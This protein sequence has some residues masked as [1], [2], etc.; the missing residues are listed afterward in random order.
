MT[1]ALSA[2][3]A[4][5]RSRTRAAR[6]RLRSAARSA[7]TSSCSRSTKC[8]SSGSRRP[9]AGTATRSRS[10]AVFSEGADGSTH[11]PADRTGSSS[12]PTWA[13]RTRSCPKDVK[14]PVVQPRGAAGKARQVR[15]PDHPR[16]REV[17]WRQ[18]VRRPARAQ[19]AQLAGLGDQGRRLRDLGE[20]AA[21]R[22]ETAGS[23]TRAEAR[24]RQVA[25]GGGTAHH[26]RHRH[27]YSGDDG[28]P[29][30]SAQ[31][32]R[33]RRASGPAARAAQGPAGRR[34]LAPPGRRSRGAGRPAAS[35]SSSARTWTRTASRGGCSCA[36]RAGRS[37]ATA[38]STA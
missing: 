9:S 3:T 11:G 34:V 17:P 18:P 26:D 37:R 2:P 4:A 29:R 24:H 14:A 10:P 32:H 31:A 7:A 23:S 20:R 36:T 22:R 15:R 21:S 30:L 33:R 6:S 25:R 28:V 5:S 35:W 8:S 27:L 13:R 16:G 1:A 12:G 19:P 38:S